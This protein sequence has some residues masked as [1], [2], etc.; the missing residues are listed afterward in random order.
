MAVDNQPNIVQVLEREGVSLKRDGKLLTGKCPLHADDTPSLKVFPTNNSWYCFGCQTGGDPIRFI[1]LLHSKDFKGACDHLGIQLENDKPVHQRVVETF[2]YTD[3]T[4]TYYKDRL[5]PGKN[6]RKKEF[7]QWSMKDGERQYTRGCDPLIYNADKISTVKAVIFTEGEKKADLI[8][9]WWKD[10]GVLGVCLDA[11]AGSPWSDSYTEALRGIEKLIILPDNDD[12]G[13]KYAAMVAENASKVV[14]EVKIVRLPGLAVKGDV[15]DW[16]K[17]GGTEE[18]L[19]EIIKATPVW[20]KDLIPVQPEQIR[21]T[22][23]SIFDDSLRY[24][25]GIKSGDIKFIPACSL[26]KSH[27]EAYVPKHINVISGYTSAGKSTMLAQMLVELGRQ[28]AGADVFSLEDS[29]EEKFMTMIAVM[30]GIHK[31]KMVLGKFSD[32]ESRV[33]NAAAAEILSWNIRIFDDIRTLTDMEKIIKASTAQVVCLDYVQNLFID[34]H[35]IYERMSYAAQEI[36]RMATEHN[37][38]WNVLSQVSNESVVNESD[39]MGLKGA[40]ELAAISN[41]VMNLKKGRKQDDMHRVI[42]GVKKN[43]TFGPC[44]DIDL[45]YSDCWT[46]LERNDAGRAIENNRYG[47]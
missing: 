17:S 10:G 18:K 5:E 22:M 1:M 32:D 33:I 11:G 28:G 46:R 45:N 15:L 25:G 7:R 37:K 2:T 41:S 19:V 42:L 40:G 6:G 3:G 9:S 21:A 36:F 29:R 8:N 34:K 38:T 44:G 16:E 20:S 14:S 12:A 30:T 4:H 43:K 24:W 47:D 23:E 27:V 39:L 26:F 31:R 35:T 13:E